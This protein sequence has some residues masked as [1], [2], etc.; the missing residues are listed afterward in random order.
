MMIK[1]YPCPCCGHLVHTG[2]PG[3]YH[4][5][6][7]CL[8]EDDQ[9]QLRWPLYPGGANELSLVDAQQT[10][11]AIGVSASRLSGSAR[12][13]TGNEP[14]DENFRPIDLSV[15]SFEETLVQEVPW[16]E[17]RSVLYWWRPTFWRQ[18]KDQSPS[19]A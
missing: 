8:W 9:V 7:V 2:S 1:R 14:I 13:P 5:C 4:V 12:P 18:D 3:S 10:Y 6:P 11:R 17:D 16:P 19:S 15:D